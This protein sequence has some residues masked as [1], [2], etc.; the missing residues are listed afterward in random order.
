MKVKVLRKTMKQYKDLVSSLGSHAEYIDVPSTVE[1]IKFRGVFLNKSKFEVVVAWPVDRPPEGQEAFKKEV[2]LGG[3]P[4]EEMDR[5]VDR[6]GL[7]VF[8]GGLQ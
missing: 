2:C 1:G 7:S 4:V 8:E 3:E 6:K 5:N